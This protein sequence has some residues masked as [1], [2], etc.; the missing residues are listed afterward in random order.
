LKL[1]PGVFL[2]IFLGIKMVK[3]IKEDFYRRLILILTAA[4]ALLILFR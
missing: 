2:G 3:I 1:L 4:G